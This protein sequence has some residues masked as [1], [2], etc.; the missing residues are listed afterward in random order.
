MPFTFSHPA[1]V[2]PLKYLP[3]QWVSLTGLVVG[4]VTPDF[5]YFI[6]MR[7]ESKYSH[8]V[9]GLFWY[10]LPL[11]LILT[12]LFHDIVRNAL[13]NNLPLFLKSRLIRFNNFDWNRHFIRNWPVI[14][15]SII[16]GASSHLIWDRFT[17]A[18]GYFVDAIPLLKKHVIIS[19]HYV[20]MFAIMQQAGTLVG[21]LVV[22][23]S[24]LSFPRINNVKSNIDTMYWATAILVTTLVVGIM[25]IVGERQSYKNLVMTCLSAGLLS[26]V[27]T[28]LLMKKNKASSVP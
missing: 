17:H 12:F 22:M 19:G 25:V 5:E 28:P 15:I 13:T 26:L 9:A 2:L 10:D 20:P 23:L 4:S 27:L 21:G 16:L 6:R 14:L 18:H 24:I 8:T 3:P 7:D 11:A 1:I